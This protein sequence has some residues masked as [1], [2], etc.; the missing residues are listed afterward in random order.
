MLFVISVAA[1]QG[2]RALS[3]L[4]GNLQPHAVEF[5][6]L[7]FKKSGGYRQAKLDFQTIGATDKELAYD[8]A[9]VSQLY[10][11]KNRRIYGRITGNQ[12]P[13]HLP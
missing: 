8:E 4:R 2:D 12:L 5:N 9:G 7:Y 3:I 13:V 1:K 10:T 6:K 11:V